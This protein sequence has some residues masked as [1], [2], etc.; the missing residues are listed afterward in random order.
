MWFLL[1]LA[2]CDQ[3]RIVIIM[4]LASVHQVSDAVDIHSTM[5]NFLPQLRCPWFI[6]ELELRSNQPSCQREVGLT[7]ISKSA[8]F[9]FLEGFFVA[10]SSI[11][12]MRMQIT[13]LMFIT[14]VVSLSSVIQLLA[15]FLSCRLMLVC[16][17]A[18]QKR[19]HESTSI[20]LGSPFL[21]PS[22]TAPL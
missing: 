22:R 5:Y 9:N 3:H 13:W 1:I 7:I 8:L 19:A 15:D 18:I 6:C 4:K 21:D 16:M 11:A 20:L 10:N 14:G 17:S 12:Q 2:V